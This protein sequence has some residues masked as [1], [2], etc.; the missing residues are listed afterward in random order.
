MSL[1]S[2]GFGNPTDQTDVLDLV[3][4]ARELIC[5]EVDRVT[6]LPGDLVVG[7]GKLLF[8]HHVLEC[9]IVTLAT[10]SWLCLIISWLSDL[11]AATVI[12]W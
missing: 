1:G 5:V 2:V 11:G 10:F 7:G 3:R 6:L 4:L 9:M 8:G 12:N